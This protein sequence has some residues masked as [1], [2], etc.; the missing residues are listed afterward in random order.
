MRSAPSSWG[1]CSEKM[2]VTLSDCHLIRPS[3]YPTA[4]TRN[5]RRQAAIQGGTGM[6]ADEVCT[7]QL[8]RL[9]GKDECHLIRLSPY[10]TLTLSDRSHAERQAASR[11]S[12][13]HRDDGR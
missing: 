4:P 9:L 11:D 10:P 8:G 12:R 7:E 13:R 3:P 1:A 6:T 2:N 5:A